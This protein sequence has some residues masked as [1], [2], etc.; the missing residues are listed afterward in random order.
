MTPDFAALNPGYGCYGAR[1]PEKK[2]PGGRSRR[3]FDN[4]FDDQPIIM[5]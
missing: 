2:T 1:R 4:P 3:G 5:G